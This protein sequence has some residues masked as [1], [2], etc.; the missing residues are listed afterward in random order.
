ML[1]LQLGGIKVSF[2]LGQWALQ[3]VILQLIALGATGVAPTGTGKRNLSRRALLSAMA[4]AVAEGDGG[5]DLGGS[6]EK[7]CSTPAACERLALL[8]KPRQATNAAGCQKGTSGPCWHSTHQICS[9]LVLMDAY[10]TTD[11]NSGGWECPYGF[12]LW[13]D[14]PHGPRRPRLDASVALSESSLPSGTLFD[15]LNATN[16]THPTLAR[17]YARAAVQTRP[18]SSAAWLTLAEA[19]LNYVSPRWLVH[20]VA[21][22]ISALLRTELKAAGTTSNSGAALA[23]TF[24]IEQFPKVK[25]RIIVQHERI[26]GSRRDFGWIKAVLKGL[27]PRLCAWY[28]EKQAGFPPF[29]LSALPDEITKPPRMWQRGAP[30]PGKMMALFTTP[31]YVVNLLE[32]GAILPGVAENMASHAIAQYETFLETDMA[33]EDVDAEIRH[34]PSIL[35]D[36]FFQVQTEAPDQKQ[37]IPGY[38][39]LMAHARAACRRYI[40]EWALPEHA[41]S[42]VFN[43]EDVRKN[44]P[45]RGGWF[46]VHT[47]GSEHTPHP[48]TDSRLSVVFYPKAEPGQ[49]RILFEDPRS[50][51]YDERVA[52]GFAED[53]SGPYSVPP[54]AGNKY[55]H[56]PATGDLLIFPSWL[57]HSVESVPGQTDYRVSFAFNLQGDWIDAVP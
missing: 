47:N 3:M 52:D 29:L 42:D 41:L 56:A 34:S 45:L 43:H 14:S 46:S 17:L 44:D 13:E 24:W 31:V 50:F 1:V 51:R 32:E 26:R 12:E 18:R 25:H 30:L 40:S 15:E 39:Q 7:E 37:R 49:S 19:E 28:D 16:T 33:L 6:G 22:F 20:A 23:Q 2:G 55:S 53:V 35:N 10:T 27:E 21:T 11:R 54:F 9:P 8:P 4:D 57:W 5:K 48:H 36:I 38:T